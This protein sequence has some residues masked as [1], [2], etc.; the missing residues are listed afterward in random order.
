MNNTE[1]HERML[2]C[3]AF[4]QLVINESGVDP[5]SC[6]ASFTVNE[7]KIECM[8]HEAL[9]RFKEACDVMEMRSKAQ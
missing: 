4:F 7:K 8:L 5:Y 9:V 2:V 6:R 3:G 1:I